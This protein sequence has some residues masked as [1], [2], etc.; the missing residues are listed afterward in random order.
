MKSFRQFIQEEMIQGSGFNLPRSQMPQIKDIDNF[1]SFI[2]SFGHSSF[3]GF[4]QVDQFKPTQ[5]NYDQSKVDRIIKDWKSQLEASRAKPIIVSY[6]G[7]VVD[8][9]HRYLAA[10]QTGYEIQYRELST[11]VADSL[12]LAYEYT[13]ESPE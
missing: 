8:G 1:L 10:L 12:K 13:S 9:H 2:S 5:T 6:D 11:N 3:D 7:F 4:G